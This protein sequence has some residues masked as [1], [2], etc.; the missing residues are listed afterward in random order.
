[1]TVVY[2]NINFNDRVNDLIT[3]LGD[4][5]N[6]KFISEVI[7]TD[8]EFKFITKAEREYLRDYYELDIT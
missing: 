1:M 3:W 7:E 4:C 5:N 2:T 8:Y 6:K